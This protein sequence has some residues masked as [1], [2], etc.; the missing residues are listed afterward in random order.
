M[1]A[2]GQGLTPGSVRIWAGLAPKPDSRRSARVAPT[3]A[4][5]NVFSWQLSCPSPAEGLEPRRLV[6]CCAVPDAF[7]KSGAVQAPREL[8]SQ[9]TGLKG[10]SQAAPPQPIKVLILFHHFAPLSGK[11][12]IGSLR[13][14]VDRQYRRSLTFRSPS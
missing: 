13:A 14:R 7:R 10:V 5:A 4:P 9:F 1:T 3:G 2:K 8:S 12:T 6:S 11:V